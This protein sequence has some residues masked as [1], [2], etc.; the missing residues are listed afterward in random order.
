MKED[1]L[2][3]L[4]KELKIAFINQ[5]KRKQSFD[6]EEHL[7]DYLLTL[8]KEKIKELK[9]YVE[10][11][12]LKEENTNKQLLHF[13][14]DEKSLSFS[15]KEFENMEKNFKTVQLENET[16]TKLFEQKNEEK[17]NEAIKKLENYKGDELNEDT[18]KDLISSLSKD[19]FNQHIHQKLDKEFNT[20]FEHSL[21]NDN[22]ELFNQ[23]DKITETSDKEKVNLLADDALNSVHKGEKSAFKHGREYNVEKF[24]FDYDQQRASVMKRSLDEFSEEMKEHKTNSLTNIEL[25]NEHSMNVLIYSQE[26]DLTKLKEN[27]M[28]NLNK[29]QV[30][31]V[32]VSEPDKKLE[33]KAH[34]VINHKEIDF[35]SEQEVYSLDDIQSKVSQKAQQLK[36]D[37][38]KEAI[39]QKDKEKAKMYI[40]EGAMMSKETKLDALKLDKN[41]IMKE[42]TKRFERTYSVENNLED[43]GPFLS[44]YPNKNK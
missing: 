22:A 6:F 30:N 37:M 25:F 32:V 36:N 14:K 4:K 18:R 13:N 9:N 24:D 27:F 3:K 8:D 11:F 38:L 1:I 29:K 35:V 39:K 43:E 2:L 10:H 31:L 15:V 41:L 42:E 44:I 26:S 12:S 5:S 33:Q 40:E 19:Q 7:A 16:N 23:I 34:L 20:L 28:N 17:I 21:H